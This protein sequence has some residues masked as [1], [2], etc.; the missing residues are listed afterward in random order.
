[1]STYPKALSWLT[2]ISIAIGLLV[3]LDQIRIPFFLYYPDTT[4]TV[5]IS[6]PFD[7]CVFL[8]STLCVPITLIAARDAWRKNLRSVVFLI[9]AL[10]LAGVILLPVLFSYGIYVIYLAVVILSLARFKGP[11]NAHERSEQ[12][13]YL[14]VGATSIVALV[15]CASVYYWAAAAFSP[16]AMFGVS[17]QNLETDL[18]YAAYPIVPL[19]MLIIMS[20]WVWVPILGRA[21]PGLQG[22]ETNSDIQSKT[23]KQGMSDRRL[24]LLS[25]DVFAILSI[26][27]FYFLYAAGQLWV[28]GVDSQWRYIIPLNAL[29]GLGV[30]EAIQASFQLFHGVYLGFLLIIERVTGLSSFLVVKYAPVALAFCT[31][32]FVFLAFRDATPRNL[33]FL[34]GLCTILWIPTTMGI[35]S[36]IQAGWAAYM[37][38][39]LFLAFYLNRLGKSAYGSFVW[40]GLLSIGI[41]M[42]H[43]WTWGVFLTTLIVASLFGIRRRAHFSH[44]LRAATSALWL[45]V[46]IGVVAFVYLSGVRS[47]FS[48]ALTLYSSPF[49][50]IDSVIKVFPGALLEM[51]REWSSFLS[52]TLILLALVGGLALK[53]LQGETKR[54]LLAWVAVWCIASIMAAPIEYVP[55]NP[56]ISET[57]LGRMLYFS[58]LPILLALG[59]SKLVNASSRFVTPGPSRFARSQPAVLSAAIGAPSLSLFVFATPLIRLGS[60]MVGTLAVVLLTYRFRMKDSPRLMI[61]IVLILI[62]VN[63]AFRSLFPL[64]LDPH[65]LVLLSSV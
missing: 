58:P 56:A 13:A 20:S 60:V 46:P 6:E 29:S 3:L 53:D 5:L 11:S 39:M 18:T 12:A 48:N 34:A 33:A 17:S 1:V 52:P 21:S 50:H 16:Q 40:Q 35:S 23:H 15:E 59:V 4:D 30:F 43:P 24:L 45:S 57:A 9:S 28:V 49:L 27:L 62:I 61:T 31:S 25:L 44:G 51:S 37:V 54:Y 36:G 10:W 32:T 38:W 55:A 47:D 7:R 63:A 42:L 22:S 8:V 14:I 41:L 2:G 26:L 65:N 19:L 64:L